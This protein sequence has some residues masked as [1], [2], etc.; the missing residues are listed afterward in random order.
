MGVDRQFRARARTS[1]VGTIIGITLVLVM[2]GTLGYLLLN[3]RKI[4]KYLKDHVQVDIYLSHGT[5]EMAIM[6]MTK[7]LEQEPFARKVSYV[8]P[9]SAAARL[10]KQLGE[11]F[12]GPLTE[13]TACSCSMVM[14]SSGQSRCTQTT[15]ASMLVRSSVGL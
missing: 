15:R 14:D 5:Q 3:A 12:L 10:K 7:K 11:D 4:E 2:L 9:D 6:R 8:T 13:N 1:N